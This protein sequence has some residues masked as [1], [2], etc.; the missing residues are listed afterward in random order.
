VVIGSFAGYRSLGRHP[1]SHLG[2]HEVWN[3]SIQVLLAF[4]ISF[5][6]LGVVLI[7][8]PLYNTCPFSLRLFLFFI[9]YVQCFNYYVIEEFPLL[10]SI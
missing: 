1:S 9:L 3:T 7:G 10:V 2:P 6:K 8:L 5:E 4:G